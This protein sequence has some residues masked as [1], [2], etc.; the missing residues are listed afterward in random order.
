MIMPSW[1]RV[2]YLFALSVLLTFTPSRA[3][4]PAPDIRLD[5]GDTPRLS[6]SWYIEMSCTSDGHVYV[7]WED[8]R[9]GSYPDVYFN[10]SSDYGATWQAADIRLDTGDIPGVARSVSP[11]ISSTEDGH[12]YVVWYDDRNGSF[13]IYFNSSA[14]NGTTW[15]PSAVRIDHV[16]LADDSSYPKISSTEDG[17]V[18]IA[19]DDARFG[20]WDIYF[21]YSDDYGVTWQPFDI[22]V[23]TGDFDGQNDSWEPQVSN[24]QNG[25]VYVVWYDNRNGLNPDIYFN[26]STDYG[27]TW[28][29]SAIR[30]DTG[31]PPGN[32]SSSVPKISNTEDG[33]VYVVWRDLRSFSF[34]VFFNYSS[35]FGATW[36]PTDIRLD[37][38]PLGT[39]DSYRTEISSTS[40]GYVYVV[41]EDYRSGASIYFNYSSDY[42]A[43]W[44]LSDI[45][46]DGDPS[47]D[48]FSGDPQIGS[49][50]Y[51]NV[52]VVWSDNRDGNLDIL[53]NYST[54]NGATW[55]ATP[56]RVDTGD[57]PGAN[58]SEYPQ[59]SN[60]ANGNI[61][62]AWEDQRDGLSDIY[63]NSTSYPPPSLL[64]PT[65][66]EWALILLG[67]ILLGT[68][69][70][71]ITR[72][73]GQAYFGFRP[74]RREEYKLTY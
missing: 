1:K 43:T 31:D 55:P 13:D 41:W 6:D 47:P 39:A 40:D 70:W 35:D 17:Y 51:G 28:Q 23:D 68:V 3:D 73:D 60:T 61:Y 64:V 63:F 4:F 32:R 26:Y 56:L 57:A 15:L 16:F 36:Q 12:A 58:N 71:N 53:F 30:L 14:D 66:S 25:Y 20:A 54:D 11:Q 10:Y 45:L 50:E 5:T 48:Y 18:Y 46:I 74:P 44:Q 65:L 59:L 2:V 69:L 24:T 42:G 29:A 52:Y 34:D 37:T 49:T 8:Y 19:W 62:L 33:H 21:N 72:K 7:V 9:N 67:F 27:A 38:T 22:R